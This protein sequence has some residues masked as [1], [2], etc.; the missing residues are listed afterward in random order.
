M[1]PP[2][3]LSLRDAAIGFGGPPLFEGLTLHVQQGD[4]ACLVGRNGCGKSTLLKLI[5][6]EL[7]PDAG[8]RYEQPGLS[9]G[10]LS[11]E[12]AMKPGTIPE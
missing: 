2:P 7:E 10:H 1:A 9:I 6:G 3:L 8:E 12:P 5:S 11:Q 4:I